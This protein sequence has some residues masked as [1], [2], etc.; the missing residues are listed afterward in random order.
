VEE[1]V[2]KSVTSSYDLLKQLAP[3]ILEHQGKGEMAGFLPEGPEQRAPLKLKLNGYTLNVTYERPAAAPASDTAAGGLAIAI[4]PDEFIFAGT[5]LTITFE[6]AVAG[7]TNV[8]IVSAQEGRYVDGK[9][10][11]GRWLNGDQTHQGRHI[12][13]VPG[14]FD[15]QRVK[16]Y[17]YR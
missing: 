5:G 8:G 2:S 3:L 13:L 9:W 1:P 11:P 10:E 6:D 7:D 17:R 15:I 4:G 14:R 16:L 12:R